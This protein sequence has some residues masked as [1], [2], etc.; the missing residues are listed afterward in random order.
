VKKMKNTTRLSLSGLLTYAVLAASKV[1]AGP[2]EGWTYK[3]DGPEGVLTD[4]E[5]AIEQITNYILGFIVLIATLI[6]IYGGVLYLTA[7]GN[8]DRVGQAKKTISSGV[9]GMVIAGLAYA[10]VYFVKTI[11]TTA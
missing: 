5:T 2:S 4:P 3:P 11:L 9:I 8:D 1:N 10:I 7:A 6:I